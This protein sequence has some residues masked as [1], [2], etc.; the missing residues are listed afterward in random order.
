M[1][2][3]LT[4]SCLALLGLSQTT[5]AQS[6]AGIYGGVTYSINSTWLFDEKLWDDP[7]YKTQKTWNSAPGLALG[8]KFNKTKSLQ[9]EFIRQKQGAHYDIVDDNQDGD[10]K[11]GEKRIDLTY[12]AIP[13]LYKITSGDKVR[14]NFHIGPQFSFLKKGFEEHEFTEDGQVRITANTT[15]ITLE[16][17]LLSN[18]QGTLSLSQTEIGFKKGASYTRKTTEDFNDSDIALAFGLGME[19]DIVSGL[20]ATTNLRFNYGFKDIRS[21]EWADK[22][23]A[24]GYYDKRN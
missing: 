21:D 6:E 18:N 17:I 14:F 20:Y 15:D 11:I 24:R 7:N 5:Q 16:D 22:E 3:L 1:K 12:T 9:V 2:K 4:L 19:F 13:V 23:E 10:P 8:F